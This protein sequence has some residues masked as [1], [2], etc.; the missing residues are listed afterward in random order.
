M[1]MALFDDRKNQ[2]GLAIRIYFFR[3]LHSPFFPAAVYLISFFVTIFTHIFVHHVRC[4]CLSLQYISG[5]WGG[6]EGCGS[7]NRVGGVSGEGAVVF[8]L[9]IP[10]FCSVSVVFVGTEAEDVFV[11]K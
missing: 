11:R 6:L 2:A 7:P 5:A 10:L 9:S 4:I 8:T 1:A 3:L